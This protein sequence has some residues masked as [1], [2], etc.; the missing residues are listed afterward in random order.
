VIVIGAFV[1][2]GD[3]LSVGGSVRSGVVVGVAVRAG[4]EDP[5]ADG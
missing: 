5:A 1:A 2:V 4:V 3:G